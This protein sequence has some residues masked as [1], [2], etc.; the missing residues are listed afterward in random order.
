MISVRSEPQ[1]RVGYIGSFGIGGIRY[2]Q[3]HP[4][5]AGEVRVDFG[6]LVFSKIDPLNE[7]CKKHESWQVGFMVSPRIEPI[8][9]G[10]LEPCIV[11]Q[12]GIFQE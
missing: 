8:T 7:G 9:G 1:N 12:G 4:Q 5:E 3:N 6:R 10:K 11:W 2:S